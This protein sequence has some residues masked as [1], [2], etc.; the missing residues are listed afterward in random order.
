M[1]GQGNDSM[2]EESRCITVLEIVREY[3][4]KHGYDGLCNE[5]C[6][7]TLEDL[8]PCGE[9]MS[10]CCACYRHR[11]LSRRTGWLVS[12]DPLEKEP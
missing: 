4:E 5:E 11:D 7:C 1:E 8:E 9:M 12:T 3:L 6:G 2:S 10:D